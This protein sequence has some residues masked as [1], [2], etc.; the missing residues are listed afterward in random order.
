[1]DATLIIGII[2]AISLLGALVSFVVAGKL[3][4]DC[5]KEVMV[6]ARHVDA[7]VNTYT[8]RIQSAMSL[9]ERFKGLEA[10]V[11]HMSEAF[12]TL[13]G[14]IVTGFNQAGTDI[15]EIKERLDRLERKNQHFGAN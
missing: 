2:F 6:T 3:I 15:G 11:E 1:M 10:Q 5:Y 12:E 4:I 13:S 8:E 7:L 9:F 14:H